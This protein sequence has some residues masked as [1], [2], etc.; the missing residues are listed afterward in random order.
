VSD[1]SAMY[2]R[3]EIAKFYRKGSF[4]PL[5]SLLRRIISADMFDFKLPLLSLNR[6]MLD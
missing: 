5:K 6:E 1:P 2:R 4:P 3:Y